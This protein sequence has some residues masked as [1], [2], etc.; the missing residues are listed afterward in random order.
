MVIM[1][2]RRVV[3]YELQRLL[4]NSS[5]LHSIAGVMANDLLHTALLYVIAVHENKGEKKIRPPPW[6]DPSSLMRQ[7]NPPGRDVPEAARRRA[8]NL[9]IQS[10]KSTSRGV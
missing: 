3:Q 5:L 9:S 1:P 4:G 6:P 7:P 10:S 8:S 2:F